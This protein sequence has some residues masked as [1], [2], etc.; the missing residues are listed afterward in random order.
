MR[1]KLLLAIALLPLTASAQT[2]RFDDGT[3]LSSS[4]AQHLSLEADPLTAIAN[5]PEWME[6]RFHIAPG[7]HI[8]SH[9]PHDELLIPTSLKLTPSAQY[10]VLS[11][12]YPAGTPLHLDIG[13]GQTLSA[14]SG[15]LILRVQVL[16][17]RG[18]FTLTGTLHYQAC[19]T[20]SCFP[21]RDLPI[22]LPLTA[23]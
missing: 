13:A 21:P 9:T 15:D 20:A 6:L 16:A 3:Q 4:H 17:Q 2:I 23:R 11:T 10:R 1:D 8:N 7:F 18:D 19:D 22:S 12:S 5:K 14:Y